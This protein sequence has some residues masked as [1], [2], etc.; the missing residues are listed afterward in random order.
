MMTPVP[1]CL[2]TV[3]MTPFVLI[4]ENRVNRIG[5]KTADIV[6]S[7]HQID[8]ELY[9][10]RARDKYHEDSANTERDVVIPFGQSTCWRRGASTFRFPGADA[11]SDE[12]QR[13]SKVISKERHVILLNAGMEMT[14]LPRALFTALTGILFRR[15]C[16]NN[17]NFVA[18]WFH[19]V[20][21]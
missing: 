12:Y 10:Y 6:R 16:S 8:G 18:V 2:I 20:P 9:T 21:F 7:S 14:I 13:T 3:K 5:P 1:N 15:S 4:L 11:V 19:A 17:T